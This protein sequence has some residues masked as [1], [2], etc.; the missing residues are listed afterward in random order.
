MMHLRTPQRQ[1][2]LAQQR[3]RQ[4]VEPK[5]LFRMHAYAT[6]RW[7]NGQARTRQKWNVCVKRFGF[8][9]SA[10]RRTKAKSKATGR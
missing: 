6:R 8:Y 2:K 1:E 9:K 5:G 3:Y 7:C 4:R 10:R